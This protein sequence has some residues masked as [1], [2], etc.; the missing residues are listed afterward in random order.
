MIW[1]EADER[2][3]QK[4]QTEAKRIELKIQTEHVCAI[5]KYLADLRVIEL[6][7]IPFKDEAAYHRFIHRL[8]SQKENRDENHKIP[9]GTVKRRKPGE[10]PEWKKQR[11][12]HD[13]NCQKTG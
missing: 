10:I 3:E 5:L 4:E 2:I 12:L 1:L 9:Y 8:P 11:Q 7:Q 13:N 6:E